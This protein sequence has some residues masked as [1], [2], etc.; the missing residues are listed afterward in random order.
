MY[1][2]LK[3]SRLCTS[4]SSPWWQ[5]YSRPSVNNVAPIRR[6]IPCMRA[7]AFSNSL[8]GG[9]IIKVGTDQMDVIRVLIL[10]EAICGHPYRAGLFINVFNA[11]EIPGPRGYRM[12]DHAL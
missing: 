5:V 7:I 12:L 9:V 10:V 4:Y 2:K 6:P 1:H 8:T 11:F 3:L